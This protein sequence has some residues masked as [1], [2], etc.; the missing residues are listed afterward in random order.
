MLV[1]GA[2]C[3]EE[4]GKKGGRP[5]LEIYQRS[6]EDRSDL[7]DC[8]ERLG[9]PERTV[10]ADLAYAGRRTRLS[11][12]TDR[13]TDRK[14][15]TD[16]CLTCGRRQ[17]E[18]SAYCS[19]QCM[20]YDD[21]SPSSQRGLSSIH[22]WAKAIP[23]GPPPPP[24]SLPTVP[25]T[26][27][28]SSTHGNSRT[29]STR[30]SSSSS[31]HSS[32]SRSQYSSSGSSSPPRTPAS[33]LPTSASTSSSA[34]KPKPPHL[35]L[36]S[37]IPLPPTL[38]MSTPQP[39]PRITST[40]T[41]STPIKASSIYHPNASNS[42][43]NAKSASSSRLNGTSTSSASA[44]IATPSA[45]SA[46]GSLANHVRTWVCP[47]APAS[48]SSPH[49]SPECERADEHYPED[50]KSHPNSN[51]TQY[52]LRLPK[53]PKS[54]S[55]PP[56]PATTALKTSPPTATKSQYH[57]T[58]TTRPRGNSFSPFPTSLRACAWD[59]D[60]LSSSLSSAQ[61]EGH[62]QPEY[63]SP[64]RGIPFARAQVEQFA[65]QPQLRG[66]KASRALA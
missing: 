54:P 50:V 33:L 37:Q 57:P 18:S 32:H 48:P 56:Y 2:V 9:S 46:L 41:K 16:W 40:P 6:E 65:P 13:Q 21:P 61:H 29:A 42:T 49:C 22:A 12:K 7:A 24:P 62:H 53:S 52:T 58:R 4:E 8:D 28:S 55:H 47:S 23:P 36:H 26:T 27:A 3:E 45:H 34:Y 14:M 1:D 15:D 35:I 63:P 30:S 19:L 31:L 51:E 66:R 60:E 20:M 64:S 38:C 39:P 44:S 5:Q 10:D 11:P 25:H 43:S 59:D 17:Q